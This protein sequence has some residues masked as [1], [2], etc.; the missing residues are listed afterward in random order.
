MVTLVL[1]HPGEALTSER[2]IAES[3]AAV[4]TGLHY[5]VANNSRSSSRRPMRAM[6]VE[7]VHSVWPIQC[8]RWRRLVRSVIRGHLAENGLWV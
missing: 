8:R 6:A 1:L 7:S 2:I 4:V 5:L 3:G